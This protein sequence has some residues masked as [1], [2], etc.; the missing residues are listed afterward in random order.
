MRLL[1]AHRPTAQEMT[2]KLKLDAETLRVQTLE[3]SG[4][5]SLRGTVNAASEPQTNTC[6]PNSM[7]PTQCFTDCDCSLGCPS[8]A[9]CDPLF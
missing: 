3:L 7:F 9:P 1:I 5:S 2:R 4:S 6:P 8:I